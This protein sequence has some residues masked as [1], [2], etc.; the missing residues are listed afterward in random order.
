MVLLI[1]FND[2][3]FLGLIENT[4][5]YAFYYVLWGTLLGLVLAVFVNSLVEPFVTVMRGVIFMPV[6]TSMVAV[7]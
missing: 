1:Y 4:L 7:S 3:G 2:P 6:V 5:Y